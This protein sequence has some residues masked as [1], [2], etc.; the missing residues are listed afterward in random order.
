MKYLIITVFTCFAMNVFAQ[1]QTFDVVSYSIPTTKWQKVQNE[2]GVQLSV[3]DKKTGAYALVIIT[4]AT[5]SDAS[6]NENFN[7]DWTRLVK[8]A[9]RVDADP[10][11]LAPTKEN[12]WDIVSGNADYTDAGKKGN[13]I[14]LTATGGG[15]MV[16][17]VLMTNT[18][19]YQNELAEIINSLDLT[20][21]SFKETH[22]SSSNVMMNNKKIAGLWTYYI[23]ETNGYINGMPQYTAGYSRSEYLFKEDGTYIYRTKNWM[24]YG[25]KDILFVYE[26]GTYSANGSQITITPEKSKSGWWAKKS[27]TKEWGSFVKDFAGYKLEKKVYDYEIKYYSGSH[28]TTLIF[29][30]GQKEG[31]QEYGYSYRGN[32]ES[33]I[34]N[35]PGFKA[36]VENKSVALT[37]RQ[38]TVTGNTLQNENNNSSSSNNSNINQLYG[39]WGQYISESNTAGYDW[40]EYYFNNDGTYQFLQKNISYLYQNDI[41]FAYEKGT[42]RLNGNQL[43]L[44][45]Q[46]G[47]VESWSKAGSDKAGKLLKIEKRTLENITYTLDFHYF[48]GIKET[49]LVLQYNKQTVR[50]GPWSSNNSFKNSWLY[51][52]PFNPDKPSIE[53]PAGTKIDFKY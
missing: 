2:G 22:T 25:A 31:V 45:P 43:N 16:S 29:K 47:T 4:K 30:T 33:L 20:K 13:A 7:T 10:A 3:S 32:N 48:S 38:G 26:T 37:T 28:D 18:Q 35:P 34:D 12:G 42:Y 51:K 8:A 5:A 11:M 21:L 17:V 19:Q 52:R 6:A 36:G 23:L 24:V 15:K 44:S 46:N 27:S 1:K 39:I 9:V 50:D 41:V 49:N 14:L 40:R 53:L